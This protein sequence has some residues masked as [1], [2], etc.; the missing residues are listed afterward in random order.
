[1]SAR[2]IPLSRR[3]F[4][5][6]SA[7]AVAAGV[8][9]P[10]LPAQ[11]ADFVTIVGGPTGGSFYPISVAV[12]NA[13]STALPDTRVQVQ[14][15]GGSN[16]NVTL[17]MG[18]KAELGIALADV[19]S[20]AMRGADPKRFPKPMQGLRGIASIFPSHVHLMVRA[21]SGIKSIEDLRGRIMNVGAPGGGSETNARAI[22]AASGMSFEDL[23]RVDFLGAGDA[24]DAVRNRRIDGF[25][26]STGLG[27][28]MVQELQTGV[29]MVAV[30][31]P[32]ELVKKIGDSAYVATE[33]PSGTYQVQGLPAP[34][35]VVWTQLF[36]S[37]S[38]PAEKVRSYLE[39]IFA[40]LQKF[41]SGH[42]ALREF[43]LERAV[44]GMPIPLHDGAKTFFAAHGVT[45]G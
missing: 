4:L 10:T 1:M 14:Q 21:D 43:S 22:L 35:V 20:T 2:D 36:C 3:S 13:I 42:A 30:P 18:G 6:T 17:V 12:A 38:H 28:P 9:A 8:L 41:R 31:I 27:A 5:S 40:D 45:A 23:K 15:T 29:D 34:G 25:F 7:A 11:A 19:L 44:Q 39:A 24:G 37:E 32:A 26:L 33:I 16:L